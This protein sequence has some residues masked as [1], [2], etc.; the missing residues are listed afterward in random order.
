MKRTLILT[1]AFLLLAALVAPSLHAQ[2]AKGAGKGQGR[3]QGSRLQKRDGSCTNPGQGGCQGRG[4]GVRKQDGT[5][6]RGGTADCPT[7][8][9]APTK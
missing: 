1:P 9:K 4:Q 7:T 6:P 5:G 2:G 8:P 3:G